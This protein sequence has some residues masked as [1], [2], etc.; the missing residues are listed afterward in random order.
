MKVPPL[1]PFSRLPAFRRPAR[2]LPRPLPAGFIPY[3]GEGFALLIPSKWNPSREQ[4]FPGTVLRCVG[5]APA[6]TPCCSP[7]AAGR[8]QNPWRRQRLLA[9][10]TVQCRGSIAARDVPLHAPLS[11][12]L[13]HGPSLTA[14]PLDPPRLLPPPLPPLPHTPQV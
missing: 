2:P 3:A 8:K 14:S 7:D 10:S 9:G 1:P 12:P 13:G 6:C 11:C 5:A 4:D